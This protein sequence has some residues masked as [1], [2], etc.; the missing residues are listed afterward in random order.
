MI[1]W[2]HAFDI[3]V[4]IPMRR[5]QASRGFAK[6]CDCRDH[7]VADNDESKSARDVRSGWRSEHFGVGGACNLLRVDAVLLADSASYDTNGRGECEK[8][9]SVLRF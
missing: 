2:R 1:G 7:I 4:N 6:G 3:D 8:T 5:R 9:S